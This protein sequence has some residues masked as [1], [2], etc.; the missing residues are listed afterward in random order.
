[1][2][3]NFSKSPVGEFARLFCA[4]REAKLLISLVNNSYRN[5]S[6]IVVER[7]IRANMDCF[8]V[9]TK[10]KGSFLAFEKGFNI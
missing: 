7:S 3:R 5:S 4:S 1:M 6:K 8:E 10:I 2:A 9:H